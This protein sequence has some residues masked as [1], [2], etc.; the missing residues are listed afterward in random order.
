MTNGIKVV[1]DTPLVLELAVGAEEEW[2][3]TVDLTDQMSGEVIM[4]VYGTD[5][6][7]VDRRLS[8]NGVR[9]SRRSTARDAMHAMITELLYDASA[10]LQL[11]ARGTVPTDQHFTFPPGVGAE[12]TAFWR[13][14]LPVR[15]WCRSSER[16]R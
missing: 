14:L 8:L 15:E 16:G 1:T 12:V 2:K 11:T 6:M 3:L 4:A 13:D 7:V 10:Q 5:H 9:L